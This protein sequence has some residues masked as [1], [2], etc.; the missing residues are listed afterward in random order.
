MLT[1]A[2]IVLCGGHVVLTGTVKFIIGHMQRFANTQCWLGQRNEV[3]LCNIVTEEFDA[4][5]LVGDFTITVKIFFACTNTKQN[6]L[7]KHVKKFV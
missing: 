7:A 5:F 4:N 2:T 3:F 1:L 6:T